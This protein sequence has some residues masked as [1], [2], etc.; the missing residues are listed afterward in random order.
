MLIVCFRVPYIW[1]LFFFAHVT[2]FLTCYNFDT[3]N[4]LIINSCNNVT[5]V[6]GKYIHYEE[7]YYTI[8]YTYIIPVTSVT[9]L[10]Y[11]ISGCSD[12]TKM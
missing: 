11:S 2:T 12:V 8:I 6:T 1:A 7:H 10:Q 3:D 9:L 5:I 4:L